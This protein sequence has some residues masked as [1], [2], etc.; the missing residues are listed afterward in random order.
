M[1]L[2]LCFV[3]EH[4]ITMLTKVDYFVCSSNIWFW[5]GFLFLHLY[6]QSLHSNQFENILVFFFSLAAAWPFVSLFSLGLPRPL[7]PRAVL[8]IGKLKTSFLKQMDVLPDSDFTW[9]VKKFS[10]TAGCS[11][12]F[13]NAPLKM[14]SKLFIISKA[15][16]V[17]LI[18]LSDIAIFPS[19]KEVNQANNSL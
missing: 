8:M 9:T 2:H 17:Q 7:P 12:V 18:S 16:S 15:L 13:T 14:V 3:L 5:R 10:S 11:S 6:S 4:F 1:L 19:L